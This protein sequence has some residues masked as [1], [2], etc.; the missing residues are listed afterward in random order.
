MSF[1]EDPGTVCEICGRAT[2]GHNVCSRECDD[3]AKNAELAALRS[4]KSEAL[5]V[6]GYYAD[7]G[8]W[9]FINQ[10]DQTG[11]RYE[12]RDNKTPFIRIGGKRARVFLS[13]YPEIK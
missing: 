5:V 10:Y 13:K 8:S 9:E 7:H 3:E 11:V 6:I 2:K 12:D 4:F 1:D